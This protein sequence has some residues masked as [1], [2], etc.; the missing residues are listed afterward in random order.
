MN[1][2]VGVRGSEVPRGSMGEEFRSHVQRPRS[3]V[4]K[5]LSDRAIG[6][7]DRLRT[8]EKTVVIASCTL[9]EAIP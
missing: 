2:G 5:R 3:N 7:F 4:K 9:C 6:S 1:D 8:G